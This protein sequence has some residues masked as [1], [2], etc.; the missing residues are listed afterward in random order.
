MTSTSTC[1]SPPFHATTTDFIGHF[2][3]EHRFIHLPTTTIMPLSFS[4]TD[5]PSILNDRTDAASTSRVTLRQAASTDESNNNVPQEVSSGSPIRYRDRVSTSGQQAVYSIETSLPLNP[6]PGSVP[7]LSETSTDASR[8]HYVA[9]ALVRTA[10][11]LLM[12]NDPTQS[13]SAGG[14]VPNPLASTLA[15][16]SLLIYAHQVFRSSSVPG[17]FAHLP[18]RSTDITSPEHP[19]K[20]ILLPLL[21]RLRTLHPRH[22][23]TLLLLGCVHYAV[24]NFQESLAINEEILRI[25]ETFVSSTKSQYS[26]H[27][28]GTAGRSN[29]QLRDHLEGHG[30][31]GR[32][33][34]L[35]VESRRFQT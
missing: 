5:T 27:S 29:V 26:A 33:D 11:P 20:T 9:S 31:S 34:P 1:D 8:T 30:S 10:L 12:Q 6:Y 24:G 7:Q 3:P 21:Y 17:A 19:Y 22:L 23:P 35:V 16:D 14:I 4:R 28:W 25:D 13:S 18:P 2:W 15:R 32:R